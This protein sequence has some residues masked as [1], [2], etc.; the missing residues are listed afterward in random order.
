VGGEEVEAGSED[1]EGEIECTGIER[2]VVLVSRGDVELPGD[3]DE[4]LKVDEEWM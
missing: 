4:I 2:L 1:E 3:V